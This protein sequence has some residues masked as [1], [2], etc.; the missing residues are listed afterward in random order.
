MSTGEIIDL[1]VICLFGSTAS[2][3]TDLAIKLFREFPLDIINV[4]SA[5]IYRGM[6]IGTAKP[7]QEILNQ[8]PHRL[9]DIL[10]PEESY[11]VGHFVKD[12][13]IEIKRSHDK[14]RIPLLVGGTMLY[15]HA[16]IEGLSDLPEGDSNI[17]NT[18]NLEAKEMGWPKMHQKLASIDILAAKKIN[19]NDGQRIQ[20]ALEIFEL[21][22]RNISTWQAK[23]IKNNNYRF[24]KFAIT[25]H[26]RAEIHQR[27][28]DRFIKMMDEGFLQEVKNLMERQ[29]LT[30]NHSS[31]RAVGYRQIWSY[32]E[33]Q[34]S[35]EEAV[36]RGQAA[37][38]Q[39][40]KRQITWLRNTTNAISVDCD[41]KNIFG[42]ISSEIKK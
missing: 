13:N 20:R 40:A 22:G 41:N 8:F 27:I 18:I 7:K 2:G 38:R 30:S 37:T 9:I 12:A 17:R 24:I 39:F 32:L 4:D 5:Q 26:V 3:K 16:L 11:S 25:H 35:I 29:Y 1:P 23:K 42:I 36:R 21:S 6:D 14:G 31:M 19:P 28:N 34:M 33:G 10:D 15:F